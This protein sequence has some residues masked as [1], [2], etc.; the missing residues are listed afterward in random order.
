[1][2]GDKFETAKESGSALGAGT[3][4]DWRAN[5]R[6]KTKKSAKGAAA[7]A[8]ERSRE[9]RDSETDYK[10]FVVDDQGQAWPDDDKIIK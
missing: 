1:M 8:V 2:K 6:T 10:G 7:I 5:A 4:S 3:G 9:S